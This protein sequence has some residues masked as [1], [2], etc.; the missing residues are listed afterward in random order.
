[1]Q[2]IMFTT[3]NNASNSGY[4]LEKAKY[5]ITGVWQLD[6]FDNYVVNQPI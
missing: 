4:Y 2:K 1:M 5:I 6:N 3:N